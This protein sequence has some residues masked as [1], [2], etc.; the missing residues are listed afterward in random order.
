[1]ACWRGVQNIEAAN[2]AL[3]C[4]C[5]EGGRLRGRRAMRADADDTRKVD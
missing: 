5:G 2:L 4:A 1:M 3:G